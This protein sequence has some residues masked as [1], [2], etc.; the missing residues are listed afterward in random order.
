MQNYIDYAEYK[1][2]LDSAER[3]EL[4]EEITELKQS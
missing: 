1:N 2:C 4:Q 3:A